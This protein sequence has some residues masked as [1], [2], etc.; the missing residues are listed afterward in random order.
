MEAMC[1]IGQAVQRISLPVSRAGAGAEQFSFRNKGNDFVSSSRQ[2]KNKMV[3]S[4]I[5]G[6]EVLDFLGQPPEDCGI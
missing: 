6:N 5:L 2:M 4:R 3:S 1:Q